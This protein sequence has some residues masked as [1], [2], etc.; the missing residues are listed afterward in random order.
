[1][2]R[3]RMLALPLAHRQRPEG[4][5]SELVRERVLLARLGLSS[6]DKGQSCVRFGAKHGRRQ[7]EVGLATSVAEV[8]E[9]LPGPP[10]CRR[11][12]WTCAVCKWGQLRSEC[13]A[14]AQ[15]L[16]GLPHEC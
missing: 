8:C 3:A 7:R 14:H 15:E 9:R 6:L 10:P 13:D 2:L 4:H 5:C 12:A 16:G 1:M 11:L